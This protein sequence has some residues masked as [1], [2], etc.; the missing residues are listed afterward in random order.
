MFELRKE[1]K[2]LRELFHEALMNVTGEL[3]F[4][5]YIRNT[6][7]PF[8]ARWLKQ[9]NTTRRLIIKRNARAMEIH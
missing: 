9:K 8:L 5:A 7:R 3:R 6:K 1:M 2:S 4:R